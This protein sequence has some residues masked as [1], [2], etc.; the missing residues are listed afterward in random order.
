MRLFIKIIKG[1]LVGLGSILPGISGGMIA[2]AFNIYKELIEALNN[3][4]KKPIK[5]VLS[6]WEYLVGI[7]LGIAIGFVLIATVLK[8]FPIPITALFVGLIL[9]GTPEVIKDIKKEKKR[10]YHYLI[11]LVSILLM[12][13]ILML[14]PADIYNTSGVA[15]YLIYMVIGILTALSLIVPGLSGT[16]ILMALGFYTYFTET[17]SNFIKAGIKFDFVTVFDN[18]IPVS[19]IA[20]GGLLGLIVFAKII[21]YFLHKQKLAFDMAVLGILIVSPINIFWSLYL[22]DNSVYD[23]L[24]FWN[25]VLAVG[26]LGLGVLGAYKLLN[27]KNKNEGDK[28]ETKESV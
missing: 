25:I 26:A 6:I 4:T 22:E 8:L 5:A 18:L 20:L 14:K 16:M 23:N 7:V 17:V 9:G 15:L 13:M 21:H 28:Y 19:I 2:A 27:F 3:V 24:G 10:W 1:T 11:T 12:V